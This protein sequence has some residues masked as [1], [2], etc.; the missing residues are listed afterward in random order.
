VARAHRHFVS[1]QV[2]HI[3]HRCHKREFLLKY[4][5]DRHRWLQWL[6]KAKKRYGLVILNYAV[7]SNHIHLLAYDSSDQDVIPKSMQLVAGRTGQEY[8]IRKRRKGAF[9]EDRYHATIIEGGEHLL[10]CIVYIDMNMVRARVVEHPAQWVH[11]GYKEIQAP[12]RKCILIDYE[13]LQK[14]CGFDQYES[15]QTA[16]RRWVETAVS[17]EIPQ[18][19]P[20]W[21]QAVAVGSESF[22]DKIKKQLK[23][24]AIGRRIVPTTDGWELREETSSYNP[25]LEGQKVDI[26]L[27]NTYPWEESSALS[28][29]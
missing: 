1:G 11:G 27:E 20:T 8:N 10:R 2:Y 16:H 5:K 28:L 23:A 15:F 4:A 6:F 24:L 7:T 18:R 22:V 14:L 3:T 26:A 29:P 17:E 12:R 9:W 21:T 13:R 25:F 19:E